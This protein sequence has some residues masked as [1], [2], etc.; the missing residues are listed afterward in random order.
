MGGLGVLGTLL[1]I[2]Q[3][4]GTHTPLQFKLGA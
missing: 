4:Q 3:Y 1:G 2:D